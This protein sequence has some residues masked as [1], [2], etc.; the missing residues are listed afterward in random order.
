MST[1]PM[2]RAERDD[3]IR[4]AK[5]RERTAK[6]DAKRRSAEMM[7][8]FEM[9]LAAQ[10]SYDDRKLWSKLKA[11]AEAAVAE[12]DR[13]LAEDCRRLGIPENFRPEIGMYWRG[14][15]ENASKERRAELRK[16]M[17]SRLIALEGAAIEAIERNTL[18]FV[19]RAIESSLGSEEARALLA[20]MP[21]IEQLMPPL[22]YTSI[23][24]SL[25]RGP[26]ASILRAAG[27]LTD[28]SDD[29]AGGGP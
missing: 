16:V 21:S 4:L 6:S 22:D 2:T 11:S 25:L 26:E 3:L 13:K 9:K 8:D 19:T 18:D 24:R 29:S 1:R 17:A 7:A 28:E 14:R 10:F 5:L 15:G 27:L 23:Q 20:A 12:A